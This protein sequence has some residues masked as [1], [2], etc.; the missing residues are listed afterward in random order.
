MKKIILL[1]I[2]FALS[3]GSCASHCNCWKNKHY[4]DVQIKQADTLQ[5]VFINNQIIMLR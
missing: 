2:L 3:L 1:F 4:V 5:Y